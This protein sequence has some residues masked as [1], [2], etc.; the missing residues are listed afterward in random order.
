MV[1]KTGPVRQE[2][3][4]FNTVRLQ[5]LIFSMANPPPPLNFQT[6]CITDK[7]T[8]EPLHAATWWALVKTPST[9]SPN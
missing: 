8:E 9:F 7:V 3:S 4:I 2:K 6:A 1:L 5:Q